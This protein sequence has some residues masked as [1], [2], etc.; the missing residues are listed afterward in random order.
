M[1]EARSRAARCSDRR[2]PEFDHVYG[3]YVPKRGDT[4]L[5]LHSERIVRKE[6]SSRPNQPYVPA[7]ARRRSVRHVWF[8]RRAHNGEDKRGRPTL[9]SSKLEQ[10]FSEE[11]HGD[12]VH[13]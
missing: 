10:T 9:T 11:N 8:G 3:T 2:K 7:N 12:A 4:I 5:N 1:V 13:A 6:G